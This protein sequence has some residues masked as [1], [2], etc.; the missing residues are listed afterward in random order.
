MARYRATFGGWLQAWAP[1]AE[2]FTVAHVNHQMIGTAVK[3]TEIVRADETSGLLETVEFQQLLDGPTHTICALHKLDGRLTVSYDAVD[4]ILF[5]STFAPGSNKLIPNSEAHVALGYSVAPQQTIH[6]PTGPCDEFF[7]LPLLYELDL[8]RLGVKTAGFSPLGHS[9]FYNSSG[10]IAATAEEADA[11]I[12]EC[13][14]YILSGEFLLPA[15]S[16]HE[17]PKQRLLAAVYTTDRLFKFLS[18]KINASD[19]E[20]IEAYEHGHQVSMKTTVTSTQAVEQRL[21]GVSLVSADLFAAWTSLRSTQ[22]RDMK[23]ALVMARVSIGYSQ[24]LGAQQVL[25]ERASGTVAAEVE[26][27]L[28]VVRRAL[29]LRESGQQV[30]NRVAYASPMLTSQY[31]G[32][33]T[34]RAQ[35][36]LVASVVGGNLADAS[37]LFTAASIT[38]AAPSVPH[39]A[40]GIGLSGAGLPE[41]CS[42]YRN[43]TLPTPEG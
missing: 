40:L 5:A 8:S 21:P 13:S 37:S 6:Q 33:F 28:V 27:L 20:S 2:L 43:S 35:L 29:G 41:P 9:G 11:I 31:A 10:T 26:P 42:P 4:T 30:A 38:M 24:A 18:V 22:Q 25:R 14:E 23:S 36:S 32:L 16:L 34:L 15:Q 1:G 19:L 12:A 7:L 39:A 17:A 3:L